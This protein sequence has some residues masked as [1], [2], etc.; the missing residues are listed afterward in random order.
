MIKML[1]SLMLFSVPAMADSEPPARIVGP[2]I[3]LQ[4]ID[5][6]I[7]GKVGENLV[8]GAQFND[9]FGSSVMVRKNKII[10]KSQ[11]KKSGKQII[12]VI[13]KT[14]R[15]TYKLEFVKIDQE[16]STLH[17]L[18]NG[19]DLVVTVKADAFKNNHFINPH[20]FVTGPKGLK[21]HYKVVGGQACYGCSMNL[22]FMI[23]AAVLA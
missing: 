12:G 14:S 6:G 16:K 9:Q 2:N 21:F 22:A 7:A 10:T 17:F 13:Q 1:F 3:D 5:H 11:F 23:L 15:Q 4:F 8:F 20:Y 19:E 18:L